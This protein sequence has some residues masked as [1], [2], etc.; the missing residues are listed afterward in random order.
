MARAS[1]EPTPERLAFV[2][3]RNGHKIGEQLMTFDRGDGVKV[4]TQT[5]LAVKLGPVSLY[6]YRHDALE[7]WRNDRFLSLDTQ[8]NDN[9]KTQHVSARRDGSIVTIHPAGSG[10]RQASGDILPFTHWNRA[11]AKAPL[12]N[13]QDGKLLQETV[14][15]PVSGLVVLADGSSRQAE[16]VVFRGDAYIEDWYDGDGVWTGLTGR[17]KDGSTLEYRRA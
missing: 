8:T 4:R 11:I 7:R 14:A 10:P 12:F 3:L 5:E 1:A 2:A 17:L 16:G 6:R 13:P 15:A 9:G